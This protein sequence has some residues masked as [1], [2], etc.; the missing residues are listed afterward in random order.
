MHIQKISRKAV[1]VTILLVLSPLSVL[2]TDRFE[3]EFDGRDWEVGHE[4]SC[5]RSHIVEFVLKGESVCCWTELVTWQFFEGWQGRESP[6][7]VMRQL[8]HRRMIQTPTVRWQ[9]HSED[10]D[11]VLYSW[12]IENNPVIGS[13]FEL[14][15]IIKS[16]EGLLML[17]YATMNRETFS[18]NLDTWSECFK[19]FEVSR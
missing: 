19:N 12:E 8:R 17:H 10:F 14:T 13:Y 2:A 3:L 9:I 15:R 4:A 6:R 7:E 16:H 18:A 11:S 5:E 1:I